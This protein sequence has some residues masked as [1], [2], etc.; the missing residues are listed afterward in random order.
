MHAIAN[1]KDK[2][3]K[4]SIY[5][6]NYGDKSVNLQELLLNI[7]SFRLEKNPLLFILSIESSSESVEGKGCKQMTPK[8]QN[9]VSSAKATW[10]KPW[11][12]HK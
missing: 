1:R 3:E 8:L 4:L 10:Q 6:A 5:I 12:H 11:K 2:A 9:K 7:W